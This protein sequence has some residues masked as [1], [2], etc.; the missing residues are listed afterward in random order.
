MVS[1]Y[2]TFKKI[3]PDNFSYTQ[4]PV[5]HVK[6]LYL[7]CNFKGYYKTRIRTGDFTDLLA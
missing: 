1:L 2:K 3:N 7:S 5:I 4:Y 6:T